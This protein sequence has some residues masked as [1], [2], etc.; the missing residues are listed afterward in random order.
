MEGWQWAIVLKPIGMLLLMGG[1]VLPIELQL[2]RF[3]PASSLKR[4][5][6]DRTFSYRHPGQ[7]MIVWVALMVLLWGSI[8]LFYFREGL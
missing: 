1:I 6:F 8:W 7:Y 2:R 5:L 4:I 3:I